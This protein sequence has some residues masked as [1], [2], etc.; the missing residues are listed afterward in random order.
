M[1]VDEPTPLDTESVD[2]PGGDTPDNPRKP[3]PG[4]LVVNEVYF[5][6]E[7]SCGMGCDANG[8]GV[9]EDQADR[10]IE[11]VNASDDYINMFAVQVLVSDKPDYTTGGSYY[12]AQVVAP[13]GGAVLIFNADPGTAMQSNFGDAI[14]LE[15]PDVMNVLNKDAKKGYI[16]VNIGGVELAEIGWQNFPIEKYASIARVP[17]VTGSFDNHPDVGGDM[18]SP[19]F[20]IDGTTPF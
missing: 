11:I 4:D 20:H 13:P 8:N 19:G 10:F 6:I 16:L 17:D 15:Q 18:F 5:T 9:R 7:G 1:L 3:A 14:V 2:P 12:F